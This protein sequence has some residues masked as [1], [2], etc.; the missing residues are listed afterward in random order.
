MCWSGWAVV[1]PVA[2]RS[3]DRAGQRV[4]AE[5]VRVRARFD[6]GRMLGLPIKF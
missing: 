4:L 1:E 3:R 6:D 2:V 5:G